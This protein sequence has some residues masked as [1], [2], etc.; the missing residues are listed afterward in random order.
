MSKLYNTY[1]E[2]KKQNK[3][4]IYLFKSGIFYIALADDATTLSNLFKFKLSNLTDTIIKCGFPCSSI[5][6]YLNLFKTYN[7]K[8]KIIES[9]KNTILSLTEFQLNE[10]IEDLLKFINN[11][12]I[13]DLSITQAYQILEELKEKV[14]VINFKK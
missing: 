10:N 2:L 9:E 5:N 8:I 1:L 3:E 7:L 13:N 12:N 6:K 4:T 11:I 14:N